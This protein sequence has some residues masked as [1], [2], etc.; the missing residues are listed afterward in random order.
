[1]VLGNGIDIWINLRT[2]TN[3]NWNDFVVIILNW[4]LD[5]CKRLESNLFSE[6]FLFMD[7]SYI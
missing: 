4:W 6:E 3:E 1:L 7:G 5:A 2:K